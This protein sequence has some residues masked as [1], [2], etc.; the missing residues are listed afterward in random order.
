MCDCCRVTQYNGHGRPELPP[1]G[2]RRPGSCCRGWR[3]GRRGGAAD[4]LGLRDA[5]VRRNARSDLLCH[6]VSDR[7]KYCFPL[8]WLLQNI[9]RSFFRKPAQQQGGAGSGPDGSPAPA[10][11]AATNLYSEGMGFDMYIYIS[12]QD[13]FNEFN[14]RKPYH[15]E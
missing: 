9:I 12:E 5:Q 13:D 15:C 3:R 11:G 6:H 8:L 14:V 10:R 7:L 4:A 1:G 2:Q